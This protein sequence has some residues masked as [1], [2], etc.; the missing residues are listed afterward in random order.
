MKK[1]IMVALL[2]TLLVGSVFAATEYKFNVGIRSGLEKGTNMDIEIKGGSGSPTVNLDTE[3]DVFFKDGLGMNII[4]GTEKFSTYNIGAG[5][6]YN[7]PIN[8]NW[9][10]VVTA[11]P[12]FSISPKG[13]SEFGVFSHFDFDFIAGR[14]FY[15]RIGT[16]FDISFLEFGNNQDT[17]TGFNMYIPIPRVAIGWKF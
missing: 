17:K 11:G 15:A 4:F 6:A 16:G 9:D 13:R 7:L 12:M 8:Q 14:Y 1:A 5:F 10:F 2:A 3:L